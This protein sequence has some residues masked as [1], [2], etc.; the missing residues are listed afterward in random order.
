MSIQDLS[1]D[2]KKALKIAELIEA[3]RN[4][5]GFPPRVEHVDAVPVQ[6]RANYDAIEGSAFGGGYPLDVDE[7]IQNRGLNPQRNQGYNAPSQ[8]EPTDSSPFGKTYVVPMEYAEKLSPKF[9]NGV[10]IEHGASILFVPSSR[11]VELIMSVVP[12]ARWTFDNN[13]LHAS[14]PHIVLDPKAGSEITFE[15]ETL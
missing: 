3:A 4:S 1:D 12:M 6:A 15:W 10:G 14:I 2:D 5:K 13:L 9:G 7:L 11:N 8:K